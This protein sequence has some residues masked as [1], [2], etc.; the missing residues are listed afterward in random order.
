MIRV[1]C[2]EECLTSLNSRSGLSVVLGIAP[3]PFLP[4]V[5][6]S[7]SL[8]LE[9]QA[10]RMSPASSLLGHLSSG[11]GSPLQPFSPCLGG[12][13]QGFVPAG[14]HN[15]CPGHVH[16]HSRL[17]YHNHWQ[18]TVAKQ[19]PGSLPCRWDTEALKREGTWPREQGW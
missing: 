15:I 17:D 11:L 16:S 1:T 2:L 14:R 5:S 18:Q 3:T 19:E 7:L 12:S 6:L 9:V 8:S 10:S 13:A 4:L